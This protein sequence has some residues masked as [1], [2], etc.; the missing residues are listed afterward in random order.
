MLVDDEPFILRGLE[1]LIDWEA[2]GFTIVKLAENGQEALD[3]LREHQ[4]DLIFADIKMPVMDGIS[5][6]ERIFDEKLS[7]ALTVILSGYNDFKYAQTVMRYNCM[8]YMLKPIQKEQLLEVLRRAA[9]KSPQHKGTAL[10]TGNAGKTD[11]NPVGFHPAGQRGTGGY[12][13]HERMVPD[14][15]SCT[16]CPY[17]NESCKTG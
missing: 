6:L 9:R 3:Y 13:E 5:L 12:Q 14:E 15:R 17:R 10:E 11:R 16:L 2:E 8:E 4:V 7:D 1:V